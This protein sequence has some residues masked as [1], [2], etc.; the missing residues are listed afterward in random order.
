MTRHWETTTSI[1]LEEKIERLE[2]KL[3]KLQTSQKKDE[4]NSVVSVICFSGEWDRLFAAL[5]I[6]SGSLAM[7]ME[8]HLF[9]TFWSVGSLSGILDKT[10][11]GNAGLQS[12]FRQMLP[13]KPQGARLSKFHF[14]G[15]GK[16]MLGKMMKKNGVD[17]IEELLQEVIDFGAHFHLCDTTG[18]LFGFDCPEK[19]KNLKMDRCGVATFLSK[20]KDSNVVLFV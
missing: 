12:F 17:N 9:L 10:A 5:T 15:L 2:R 7:G 8:V 1:H 14:L 16:Y 13:S 20:A 11:T 19:Q 3:N 6:A 4:K 18:Q